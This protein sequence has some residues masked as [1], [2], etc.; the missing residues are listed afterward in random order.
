MSVLTLLLFLFDKFILF[1]LQIEFKYD[2]LINILHSIV[3]W[4]VAWD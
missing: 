3:Q 4:C 1:S 2:Y